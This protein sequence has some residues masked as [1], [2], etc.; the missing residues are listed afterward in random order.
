MSERVEKDL[1][2]IRREIENLENEVTN[3][4][5]SL[6]EMLDLQRYYQSLTTL[7]Q[8]R[9]IALNEGLRNLIDENKNKLE[10]RTSINASD[11]RDLLQ[12]WTSSQKETISSKLIET[13][14]L[15]ENLKESI[16]SMLSESKSMYGDFTTSFNNNI[17]T[18]IGTHTQDLERLANNQIN[19]FRKAVTGAKENA[20]ELRSNSIG[21]FEKN[22]EEMKNQLDENIN[23]TE[24]IMLESIEHLRSEY[25]DKLTENMESIFE[26][27]N[28]IKN[29]LEQLV[30]NAVK[31]IQAE[32]SG[33]SNTM[34]KYLVD[35]IAKIQDV[36]AE[37]EKGMIDVNEVAMSNFNSSKAD[38][39]KKY[40]GVAKEQLE[41]H[42]TELHGFEQG[43]NEEVDNIL[44]SFSEQSDTMKQEAKSL[45]SNEQEKLSSKFV[46]MKNSLENK[47]SELDGRSKS[48]L[49]E[50]ISTI[51]QEVANITGAIERTSGQIISRMESAEKDS[52]A[53]LTSF[54]S[55][56]KSDVV[57]TQE[58]TFVDLDTEAK[59]NIKLAEEA[60]KRKRDL[61]G[62]LERLEKNIESIKNE[63][64]R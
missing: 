13:N 44:T 14:E 8:N 40:D 34:D 41:T 19:T 53:D 11:N 32:L 25:G 18:V 58:T 5:V 26:S 9:F 17:S 21:T 56:A 23:I 48:A 35:E 16:V 15:L 29:D 37:Y 42:S 46:E 4:K 31:R 1:E 55:K 30:S 49:E 6:E 20:A 24:N 59:Q 62:R 60:E 63:L 3:S 38:M 36:L 27:F 12:E 22:A 61:I 57:E 64:Y 39:L 54:A 43:F 50:K 52:V 7:I 28:R 47:I 51:E 33:V 2:K 10:E 45:L